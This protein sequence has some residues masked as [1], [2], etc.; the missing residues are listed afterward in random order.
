MKFTLA[1]MEVI[2]GDI[3]EN[4]LKIEYLATCAAEAGSK[5]V[6]FPEM[7][8]SG[9]L[10]GDLWTNDE[11]C[12]YLDSLN[13]KIID[14]SKEL[15]IAIIWGNICLDKNLNLK[16]QDGRRRKYNAA[17]CY[18]NGE[19]ANLEY[20]ESGCLYL[21]KQGISAIIKT[22]LPNYRFFDDKRYFHSAQQV[23]L[24]QG[25]SI[26]DFQ[27]PFAIKHEEKLI[28][29][30]V[31]IC[32][33]LWCEDYK[34]SNLTTCDPTAYL[35]S[36][37]ETLFKP[38]LIVNCSASPW[39]YGKNEARDRRVK[40][41]YK[42][43]MYNREIVFAYVNCVGVQNNGKNFITFDGGST[44]YNQHGN[45]IKT[46]TKKSFKPCLIHQDFENVKK[47]EVIV[48]NQPPKI[49]Q[50]F[51]A[52]S[53]A[54]G[55]FKQASGWTEN[56]KVVIGLSGGIDS[57]VTACLFTHAYGPQNIVLVNMPSV[58]N[59]RRTK[60]AAASIAKSLNCK[61]IEIPI[62]RLCRLNKDILNKAINNDTLNPLVEENI[63]AKIRGT[64]I[65]SNLAQQLGGIWTNN[66][67]K[68]E[69]LL[70]YATL[71]GDWGGAISPLGDLTKSEVYDLA[72]YINSHFL[73]TYGVDPI[74]QEMIPN[75]LYKFDKTK[76]MPS[77][78]LK[79]D[80]VDPIKIGYHCALIDN[81]LNYIKMP[82]SEIIEAW[83]DGTLH[84]KLNINV[85]L[86][87]EVTIY[88]S[89][90]TDLKWFMGQLRKQVFKRVQSVPLIVTSKTAFGYDLRESILP[91]DDFEIPKVQE[92]MQRA[93]QKG[94]YTPNID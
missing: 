17:F 79:H 53:Y 59:S 72:V 8:I 26:R 10:L 34:T 58:Y 85:A 80:Q 57:A 50:K 70:G 87:E 94:F 14:L 4:L 35:L 65:L 78:E 5:L 92:A 61:Y 81:V 48:R 42:H 22:N 33:D 39:T 13:Q 68:I 27:Y 71:Y 43:Q 23:A 74:P 45:I 47:E 54:L 31:E 29:V 15:N 73:K 12:E 67:N 63:Q 90:I 6:C 3:Q 38:I 69:N 52:I 46:D 24:E 41:I 32:E 66:G 28:P 18:Q 2:P 84:Q 62:Q 21:K 9:Y 75:N 55:K 40:A 30:G 25:I 88:E 86:L 83:A 7:C 44:I 77:A 11:F 20:R 1:Q 64:T 37:N 60:N 16:N 56:P 51:E 89:F 49:E 82:L 36:W 19:P 76:I 93:R 91:F